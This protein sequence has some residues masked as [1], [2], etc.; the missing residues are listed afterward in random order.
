MIRISRFR[1]FVKRFIPQHQRRRLSRIV[2]HL[3]RIFQRFT[4][5]YVRWPQSLLV[6]DSSIELC[7][8]EGLID[9]LKKAGAQ[10][11]ERG[12]S[13]L[14]SSLSEI[15]KVSI[16][17]ASEY[18]HAFDLEIFPEI[19]ME[20]TRGV[21]NNGFATE[22]ITPDMV[23]T[24]QMRMLVSN[25]LS[26][27]RIAPRI[28]DVLRLRCGQSYYFALVI[29]H[30]EGGV[31]NVEKGLEFVSKIKRIIEREGL[32]VQR[33]VVDA[34]LGLLPPNFGG[35]ILEDASGNC[36]L[37]DCSDLTLKKYDKTMMDYLDSTRR[38]AQMSDSEIPRRPNFYYQS[39]PFLE[40]AGKRD[41]SSRVGF[42]EGMLERNGYVF[43][44][45]KVLD[46]GCNIG[47]FGAYMLHKGA[48]WYTGLDQ[49]LVVDGGRRIL[50]YGGYSRFDLIASNLLVDDVN[51]ILPTH[52]FDLVLF[53]AMREH[54]GLPE[55]LPS[56]SYKFLLYEGHVTESIEESLEFL[57]QNLPNIRIL[58]EAIWTERD[59]S[60]RPVVLCEGLDV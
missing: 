29:E 14:I 2:Q 37:V 54:I 57:T 22:L 52:E 36:Y 33:G 38:L 49:P 18:P 13:I 55:W 25:I 27:Y 45:S 58:E 4:V 12:Q 15:K 39:I 8:H 44:R 32:V 40:P 43:D 3:N 23:D 31:P 51:C 26:T 60:C 6:F 53:L 41:M 17:L 28:Y 5:G 50:Y 46:I 24:L 16:S 30:L 19:C 59:S 48:G 1:E 56:L 42:L 11:K 21:H 7:G 47:M 9:A 35:K 34:A 10:C 20:V